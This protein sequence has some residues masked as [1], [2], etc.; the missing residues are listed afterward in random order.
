MAVTDDTS[1]DG[2]ETQDESKGRPR[3][4]VSGWRRLAKIV[5]RDPEH[6]CERLALYVTQTL[7][8]DSSASYRPCRVPVRNLYA[9]CPD[10][11]GAI[12]S[13]DLR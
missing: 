8:A 10:L 9:S 11:Y 1:P 13:A 2:V 6:V 5:Y 3:H 4:T 12:T 7:G